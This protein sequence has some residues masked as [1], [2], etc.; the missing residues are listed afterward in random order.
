MSLKADFFQLTRELYEKSNLKGGP[1]S[2]G[3]A[4]QEDRDVQKHNA[5]L[6]SKR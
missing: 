1:V 4:N 2:G 3:G 6:R 5:S